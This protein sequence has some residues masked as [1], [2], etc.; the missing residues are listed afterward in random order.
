M[1][2][3]RNFRG[4]YTKHT[5]RRFNIINTRQFNAS[6]LV[7]TLTSMTMNNR[8][9][10]RQIISRTRTQR[11]F[12]NTNNK[13]RQTFRQRRHTII[14]TAATIRNS[15]FFNTRTQRRIEA[16]S[17]FRPRR[18]NISRHPTIHRHLHPATILVRRRTVR[19]S[20]Q[21]SP[22]LHNSMVTP[23]RFNRHFA[24]HTSTSLR[25]LDRLVLTKRRR[26]ILRRTTFSTPSGLISRPLF[27]I[28]SSLFGRMRDSGQGE[29]KQT[30]SVSKE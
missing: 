20:S 24:R 18:F 29:T 8:N 1:Y 15:R 7:T 6:P 26:A 14:N 16:V 27:L 9:S 25:F 3:T 17:H 4:C 28:G 12:R 21:T 5:A 10:N 30:E 23:F 11:T 19:D 2:N 13:G 22:T